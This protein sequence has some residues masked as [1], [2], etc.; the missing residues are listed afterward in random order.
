[1]T[2]PREELSSLLA[3][4]PILHA[5]ALVSDL[6]I[7]DLLAG[8]P[9]TAADLAEATGSHEDSLYRVLRALAS[10]G[11]LAEE[12]DGT[13]ALTPISQLLRTDVPDSLHAV[14]VLAGEPWRRAWYDLPHAVRTG[15]PAFGRGDGAAFYDSLAKDPVASRRFDDAMRLK[16]ETLAGEVLRAYDFS[17]ASQIVDVGGGSGML[18][19]AILDAHPRAAG[20]LFET[21]A[22]GIEARGRRRAATGDFFDAVPNGG[23]LYVLA[24]VLHNW[25]DDAAVTILRNCR[26]AMAD[27]GRVI[28]IESIVPDDP[29]PSAAKIHD[30]EMLVFM[31]GGR[32][33]TQAEYGALLAEAG[34]RLGRVIPTR[35]S[36]S[37]LDAD[38]AV[39]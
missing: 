39:S 13:F 31:P 33:R 29:C 5:I 37:L 22:M 30:L 15:Q 17:H 28:V 3:G 10:A 32:E 21:Q 24:F 1:V 19:E 23:D 6:S 11:V 2:D 26:R 14:A 16:W 36:A 18:L 34:L 35:T 7:P 25:D 38:V 4:A 12:R 20:V 9:R 8:G 27:G